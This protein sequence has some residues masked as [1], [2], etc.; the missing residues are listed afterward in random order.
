MGIRAINWMS[1][2]NKSLV[3]SFIWSLRLAVHFYKSDNLVLFWS[4]LLLICSAN[5]EFDFIVE[6]GEISEV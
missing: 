6:F 1:M 2:G 4:L 5:Y 3:L